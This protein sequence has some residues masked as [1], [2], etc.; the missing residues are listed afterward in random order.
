ML[1]I[2]IAVTSAIVHVL[3]VR[4]LGAIS[5]KVAEVVMR[6]RVGGDHTA[7][8]ELPSKPLAVT[9]SAIVVLSYWTAAIAGLAG[10]WMLS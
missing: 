4:Q 2:Q 5:D 7:A 10:V 1:L 6:V 9:V 8:A 3:A